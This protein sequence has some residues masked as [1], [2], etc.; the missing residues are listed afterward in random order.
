MMSVIKVKC[1][2][3]LSK[4]QGRRRIVWLDCKFALPSIVGFLC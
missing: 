3:Q 4:K 1:R 2:K